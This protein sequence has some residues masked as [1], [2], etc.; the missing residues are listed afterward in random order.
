[1]KYSRA[2]SRAARNS[3][4]LLMKC[5]R[6]LAAG[7]ALLACARSQTVDEHEIVR[8]IRERIVAH[9]RSGKMQ[10]YKV[11]IPNTTISYGMAPIP[12]GDFTMGSTQKKEEQPTN[13]V[14]VDGFWM[15]V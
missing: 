8:R 6:I 14:H 4:S 1:M 11:T 10:A 15:Q 9:A 3:S 5:F 2:P 7:L 12:A 13:K